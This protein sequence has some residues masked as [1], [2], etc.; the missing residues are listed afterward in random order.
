[1]DSNLTNIEE[2]YKEVS[3]Q[4]PGL[5]LAQFN[6]ICK[7]PFKFVKEVMSS[8]DLKDIRLKY[9]GVFEVSSSKV[10]FV[11]KNIKKSF[12]KGNISKERYEKKLKILES[13]EN[14]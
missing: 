2:Y 13:Y 3:Q 9:F 10:K 6:D 8:G 1:M 5:T 14:S 4:Y 7:Y 12:A 11:K